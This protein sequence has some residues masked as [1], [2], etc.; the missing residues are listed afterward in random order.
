MEQGQVN[1]G[2]MRAVGRR[3]RAAFQRENGSSTVEF[4]MWFPVF[5]TLFLTSFELS[6]Y[7]M[8]VFMLDRA[9]DQTVRD[10]RLGVSRPQNTAEFK[11][12]VCDRVLLKGDCVADTSVQLMRVNAGTWNFPTG[13]VPCVDRVQPLTPKQEDANY[14]TGGGGDLMLLLVC[15]KKRPFFGSTP[16]V[17]GIPEDEH[18]E[19]ALAAITTFVNEP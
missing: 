8:R 5:M 14:S 19:I 1:K 3:L 6:F 15:Q 10:L 9:V 7:G 2:W 13:Q 16:Y 4:V 18:G 11:T 17:M 12:A